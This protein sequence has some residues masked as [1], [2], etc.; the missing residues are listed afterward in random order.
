LRYRNP[1]SGVKYR[2][3]MERL[4]YPKYLAHY[5]LKLLTTPLSS[6][7]LF[8]EAMFPLDKKGI[9][10]I[11][12]FYWVVHRYTLPWIHE[13]DQS[14]GQYFSD[15]VHF[16]GLV[17]KRIVRVSASILNARLC[18]AVV[19]W[20]NHA[21]RG[22]TEDG[23][24]PSKIVVIP[25]PFPIIKDRRPHETVN[26]LFLGRDYHRKGG[27]IAV[28]VFRKL[29]KR[30]GNVRLIYVGK[31]LDPAT[32]RFLRGEK[33]ISYYESASQESLMNDIFPVSDILLLPCRAEAYGMSAVE[34]MSR[35]IPV[36]SSN[37]SALPEILEDGNSGYLCRP[38]HV[39]SFAECTERLAADSEL[40]LK[41]GQNA[42]GLVSR[43]FSAE[44]IGK[45]LQRLY[46]EAAS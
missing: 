32:L 30:P 18:R 14:L 39:D 21:K 45:Q 24:D 3:Q 5:S 26:I 6:A 22:Y 33:N 17:S 10:L 9:S 34:A 1:P 40:R 29:S 28:E 8:A 13:N 31:V 35:G 44:Q 36:I 11:H 23:V 42:A 27:D 15:Y 41:L 19:V 4:G 46:L 43:K 37:I 12:S 16:E 20:S 7:R 25:P 2:L 38:E